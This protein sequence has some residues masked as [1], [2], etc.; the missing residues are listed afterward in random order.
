M[1]TG[2]GCQ[3][4]VSGHIR[5]DGGSKWGAGKGKIRES[6]MKQ[7]WG[8]RTEPVIDPEVW[9]QVPNKEVRKSKRLAD[10]D[11]CSN[12]DSKAHITQKNELCI[13]GLVERRRRIEMVDTREIPILLSQAAP[14]GLPVMVVVPGHVGHQI[15]QPAA[16]LLRE[17]VRRGGNG[18]LLSQLVQLVHELA[19]ATG[20]DITRLGHEDHVTLHVPRGLVVLAVRDLPAEI[21]YQKRRMTEPS[22]GIVE[23]LR[24]RE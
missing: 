20:V 5:T 11:E 15:H 17:H 24:R 19:D 16:Q 8:E 22:H 9:S 1:A 2:R 13:L 14:L 21:G 23:G 12:G 10:I 3:R 7:S 4:D 6:M 18:G